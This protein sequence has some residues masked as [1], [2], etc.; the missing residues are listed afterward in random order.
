MFV[1]LEI[2]QNQLN[3]CRKLLK[4]QC[5]KTDYLISTFW[6][7]ETWG[8]MLNY[9]PEVTGICPPKG[10]VC[11]KQLQ[12]SA[13]IAT[14]RKS[15]RAPNILYLAPYLKRKI[16]FRLVARIFRFN[17]Q[18]LKCADRNL[19]V[20]PNSLPVMKGGFRYIPLAPVHGSLPFGLSS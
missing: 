4:H 16:C 20:A 7:C 13:W 11:S 17:V 6:D 5:R 10:S 2:S 12:F 15:K 18:I 1:A 8:Q 19:R 9:Y 14:P 3:L